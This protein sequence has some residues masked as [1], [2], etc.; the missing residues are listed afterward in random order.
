[1]EHT[2]TYIAIQDMI[3]HGLLTLIF[4]D[5]SNTLA[6][7]KER[8]LITMAEH[9][10][11]LALAEGMN[12]DTLLNWWDMISTDPTSALMST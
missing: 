3:Q 8:G 4:S 12:P 6:L 11:L 5:L 7:L 1:M 9:E 2:K 10:D